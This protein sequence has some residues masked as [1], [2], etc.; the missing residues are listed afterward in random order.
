MRVVRILKIIRV[1]LEPLPGVHFV[2]R[3][4]GLEYIHQGISFVRNR[5]FENLFGLVGVADECPC[6]K[7]GIEGNRN[8]E[9]IK[10]LEKTPAT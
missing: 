6:D 3:N 1:L 5:L 10:R 8:G 9:R 2:E 4:A 7:T